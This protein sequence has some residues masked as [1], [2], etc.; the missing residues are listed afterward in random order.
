MAKHGSPEEMTP[1]V[2]LNLLARTRTQ[3]SLSRPQGS[4][5]GFSLAATFLIVLAVILGTLALANR[6]SLG[7]LGSAYDSQSREAR[8]AA[9]IGINN[10][11]SELNRRR[12]RQLL[13]NAILLD[14]QTRTILE[15]G[16]K[17]GA[18]INVPDGLANKVPDLSATF[19]TTDLKAEQTIDATKRFKLV[20]ICNSSNCSSNPPPDVY[21]ASK[22][23]GTFGPNLPPTG[24]F[25]VTIG[26]KNTPAQAGVITLTVQGFA[27]RGSTIVGTST[28]T[29]SFEV[30]PKCLDRS[31]RGINSTFGNAFG[32][33]T[34]VCTLPAGAG[35]I[36]G[37]AESNSGDLTISGK[38]KVT[39]DP[40]TCIATFTKGC[41]D[42][43]DNNTVNVVNIPL[44]D[45]LT[46]PASPAPTTSCVGIR[47]GDCNVIL[48]D[49]LTLSTAPTTATNIDTATID[50]WPWTTTATAKITAIGNVC[51]R[52]P[53]VTADPLALPL[54]ILAKP[55]EINCTMNRFEA[56]SGGGPK[57]PTLDTAG[58]PVRFFF[59]NNTSG[60]SGKNT[61]QLNNNGGFI[62]VNTANTGNL[63][64]K[65]TDLSMFGCQSCGTQVVELRNGSGTSLQLFLYFPNGDIQMGGTA[66]YTGAIWTNDFQ[67]A[68]K[69]TISIPDTVIANVVELMGLGGTQWDT[70]FNPYIDYVTRSIQS[71]RFF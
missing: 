66:D 19:T 14:T 22:T 2:L 28:V 49:S 57:N 44:P 67:S 34:R 71:M 6:N 70:A 42:N 37:A 52:T 7:V 63:P 3:R 21:S 20:S 56:I 68:G 41:I 32:N 69:N 27:Y 35:F 43:L 9:E 36:A 61:I 54:P 26:N 16:T 53:A 24:S 33:D 1:R 15:D 55:A 5:A 30:V 59:P 39:V 47:S 10:I 48:S 8:S 51:A 58:G 46:A 31:L 38:G 45:A 17:Y 23:T 18:T 60:N 29:K 62:H 12:N 25:S 4:E 64:L 65:E 50:Y 13:V 11:I 40:V